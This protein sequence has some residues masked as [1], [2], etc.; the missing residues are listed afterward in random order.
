MPR[1]RCNVL[2]RIAEQI[3]VSACVQF[4]PSTY[5]IGWSQNQSLLKWKLCCVWDHPGL[6]SLCEDVIVCMHACVFVQ[7][8]FSRNYPWYIYIFFFLRVC[9]FVLVFGCRFAWELSPILLFMG[10]SEKWWKVWKKMA[11]WWHS[12][13]FTPSGYGPLYIRS[14]H[15]KAALE[16]H[17]LPIPFVSRCLLY[18]C[19]SHQHSTHIV[20]VTLILVKAVCVLSYPVHS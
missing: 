5:R 13:M 17:M 19:W 11:Q 15:H 1:S 10:G 4:K 14:I 16:S 7:V 2:T 8:W 12:L 3:A 18:M 9:V 6:I 20:R